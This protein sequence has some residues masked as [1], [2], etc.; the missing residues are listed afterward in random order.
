MADE[1]NIFIAYADIL[2]NDK[3][4]M[5]SIKFNVLLIDCFSFKMKISKILIR[6]SLEEKVRCIFWVILE[7]K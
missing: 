6:E 7:Y 2:I 4:Q 5:R 3:K 1:C